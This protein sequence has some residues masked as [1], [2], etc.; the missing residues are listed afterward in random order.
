MQLTAHIPPRSRLI[1]CSAS[2]RPSPAVSSFYQGMLFL[3]A[4]LLL[5]AC[6]PASL[7]EEQHFQR[8]LELESSGDPRAAVI[9]WKNVLQNN[10]S[11]A[12]ARMRLGLLNLDLGDL[13]AARIELQRAAELG[14]ER[15]CWDLRWPASG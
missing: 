14:I 3:L 7:S 9:E 10:P 12:D 13:G 8:A 1:L 5:A 11:N 6:G 2:G 4:A 15:R